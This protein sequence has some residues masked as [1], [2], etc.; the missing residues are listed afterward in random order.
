MLPQLWTAS[1]AVGSRDHSCML[2]E[3]LIDICGKELA[4]AGLAITVSCTVHS[5]EVLG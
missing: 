4:T 5:V 2:V 3:F 1:E